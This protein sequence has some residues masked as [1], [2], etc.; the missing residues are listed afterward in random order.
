[1]QGVG[2]SV[3]RDPIVIPGAPAGATSGPVT[4]GHYAG[5][6]LGNARDGRGA[7]EVA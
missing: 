2:C 5:R 7:D 6:M 4:G 3:S 1:V